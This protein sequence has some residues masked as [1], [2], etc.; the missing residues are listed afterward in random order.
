MKQQTTWLN[1]KAVSQSSTLSRKK[2][3]MKDSVL[4]DFIDTKF[5]KVKLQR[6]QSKDVKG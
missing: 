1:P 6:K 5:Q 4:S 3:D 2:L